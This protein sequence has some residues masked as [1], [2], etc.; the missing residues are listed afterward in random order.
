MTSGT[1][2]LFRLVVLFSIL[3][4]GELCIGQFTLSAIFGLSLVLSLA[5]E[6]LW[7]LGDGRKSHR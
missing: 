7:V 3:L 2:I 4:A 6:G 5:A 1:G